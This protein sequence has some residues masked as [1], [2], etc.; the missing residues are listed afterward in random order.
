[1]PKKEIS[2]KDSLPL[3]QAM[4]HLENLVDSLKKGAVCMQVGREYVLFNL[5]GGVPM[6]VQVSASE[7]KG[8]N[9]ITVELT[10]REAAQKEQDA[11]PLMIGSQAPKKTKDAGPAEVP[12]TQ[13]SVGMTAVSAPEKAAGGK[14]KPANRAK[15]TAKKA[16]GLNKNQANK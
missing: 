3:H 6:E 9:R 1:M 2:Y 14:R 7:K 15:G 4:S 10:W 16:G 5:D 11:I 8:K 12:A 13:A